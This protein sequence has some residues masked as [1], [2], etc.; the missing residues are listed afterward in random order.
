MEAK[1]NTFFFSSDVDKIF[2]GLELRHFI[3]L[4]A[5]FCMKNSQESLGEDGV[6]PY[7]K[8]IFPLIF[9]KVKLFSE[10]KNKGHAV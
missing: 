4:S 9:G 7:L 8:L 3:F 2:V 10:Y 5:L 1:T 6:Q